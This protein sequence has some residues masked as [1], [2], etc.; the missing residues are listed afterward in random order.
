MKFDI[1]ILQGKTFIQTV[2]WETT[3][4]VYKAITGITRTAPIT[5]T[6][7][8]HGAPEGWRAAVTSVQGMEQ[9]NAAHVPPWDT[10]YHQ[11]TV[12][13]ADTIQFNDVNAAGYDV[14]TEGGYLQ[15]NTPQ[16][17]TDY[18]ARMTI[19][20]RV[21]GTEIASFT[22]ADGDIEV[23]EANYTIT[24]TIS[25]TDTAA[26]DFRNGVYDLEMVSPSGVVTLLMYG[27]VVLTNEVTT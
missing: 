24:L 21:G 25:A 10:D 15:Y 2:R 4:I 5:I 3:P 13:D 17:L 19:K 11:V 26:Y 8:G 23:D 12:V 6:V 27:T 20:N 1:N 14:Y 16:D 9:A 18:E 22:S 7:E